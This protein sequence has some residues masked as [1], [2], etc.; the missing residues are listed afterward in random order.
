MP[1]RKKIILISEALGTSNTAVG[2]RINSLARNLSHRYDLVIFCMDGSSF[3]PDESL[4]NDTCVTIIYFWFWKFYKNNRKSFSIRL[5]SEVFFAVQILWC[6]LILRFRETKTI[7]SSPPFFLMLIVSTV[8]LFTRRNVGID[9]RDL[10][11]EVFVMKGIISAKNIVYRTALRLTKS[12]INKSDVIVATKGL[13]LYYQKYHADK[14]FYV[15]QNGSTLSVNQ[16]DLRSERKSRLRVI[17]L[18]TLGSFQNVDLLK[19]LVNE[20]PDID[21]V[22]I[23]NNHS[24]IEWINIADNCTLHLNLDQNQLRSELL[25]CDVGLS[26][27]DDSELSRLS[28]PVKVFDYRA[29][30]LP[31]V[32]SSNQAVGH[33]YDDGML[34]KIDNP[35]ASNVGC[36][37]TRLSQ[38]GVRGS[39]L[40]PYDKLV[41]TSHD[42]DKIIED[43]LTKYEGRI[44][45]HE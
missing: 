35:C 39:G 25:E 18:G 30:G 5:I 8:L 4:K 19:K 15:L 42:R 1:M 44:L 27:R 21:F 9:V 3:V 29:C 32:Y 33:L 36:I 28:N 41:N 40:F 31:V 23:T 7:I 26:F 34:L 17:H 37:L 43:F 6:F 14:E 20:C 16:A 24:A 22:F 11:P 2:N 13:Q 10:Y 12:I 45:K 38:E